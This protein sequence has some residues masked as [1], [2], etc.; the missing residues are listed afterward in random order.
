MPNHESAKSSNI[1][2]Y[3]VSL[4]EL[5]TKLA[6]WGAAETFTLVDGD[7]EQGKDT[8]YATVWKDP[9]GCSRA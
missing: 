5:E 2:D 6:A 3:I 9:M 1:D 8:K 4:A 7:W